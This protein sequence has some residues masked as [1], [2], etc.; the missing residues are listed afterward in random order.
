MTEKCFIRPKSPSALSTRRSD[1]RRVRIGFLATL[2][3]GGR[4]RRNVVLESGPFL[5]RV[6]AAL[7]VEMRFDHSYFVW[8][9]EVQWSCGGGA[10]TGDGDGVDS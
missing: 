8:K 3:L 5:A 6:M 1:L 10:T 7:G 2:S 4:R 9:S